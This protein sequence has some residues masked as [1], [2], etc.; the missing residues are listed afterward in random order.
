MQFRHGN[1]KTQ[2]TSPTNHHPA[3]HPPPTPHPKKNKKECSPLPYVRACLYYFC[4][5]LYVV[6][7]LASLPINPNPL[8]QQKKLKTLQS[9]P[10]KP[11]LGVAHNVIISYYNRILT[12]PPL[13]TAVPDTFFHFFVFFMFHFFHITIIEYYYYEYSSSSSGTEQVGC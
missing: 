11:K 4:I 5:Y 6:L 7:P 10:I 13:T 9:S 1:K 2:S 3:H 12:V 8:L